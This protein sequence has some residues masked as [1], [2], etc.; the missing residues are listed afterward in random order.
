MNEEITIE[1]ILNKADVL[2]NTYG[3]TYS[4][5][6]KYVKKYEIE[7][8]N[9]TLILNFLLNS[10]YKKL[11]ENLVAKNLNE[12]HDYL[13]ELSNK[14]VAIRQLNLSEIAHIK[15]KEIE[16]QI[17][18]P[19]FFRKIRKEYRILLN[20]LNDLDNEAKNIVDLE[21]FKL[22]L[23]N[24]IERLRNLE[25]EIEEEKKSGLYRIILNIGVWGIPIL[26]GFYQLIAMQ[27]IAMNPY[28]PLIFY[29]IALFAV[30][31][32]FKSFSH[33]KLLYTSLKAE[34]FKNSFTILFLFLIFLISHTLIS[35]YNVGFE[36]NEKLNTIF[37]IFMLSLILVISAKEKIKKIKKK[38]IIKEF[39]D[40]E[41]KYGIEENRE[42]KNYFSTIEGL[43]SLYS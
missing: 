21:K 12:S 15:S 20:E 24:I 33:I 39:R 29:V 43:Y 11:L 26:I 10:S 2:Y 4:H 22:E 19:Y 8:N 36:F 3:E 28:L 1:K 5:I 14:F 31:F 7:E 18:N 16:Y 34:K 42:I 30:Y 9:S 32:F 38:S 13:Q 25:Y 40:L 23:E 37:A 35:V 27:Y 41:I 17:N 6:E